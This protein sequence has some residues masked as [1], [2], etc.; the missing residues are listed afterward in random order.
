MAISKPGIASL[1]I[2]LL[3]VAGSWYFWFQSA[4]IWAMAVAIVQGGL[5]LFGLFMALIGILMLV[6]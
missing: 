6:I 3:V 4:G 2:G 5:I 1:L